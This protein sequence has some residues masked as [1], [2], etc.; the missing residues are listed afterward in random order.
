M[1]ILWDRD[2]IHQGNTVNDTNS[3]SKSQLV[4]ISQRSL[5]AFIPRDSTHVYLFIQ[6]P[7][8]CER[9]AHVLHL[10]NSGKC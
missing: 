10:A 6:K 9:I 5:F 2:R 8:F 3:N 1:F 4:L 7:T